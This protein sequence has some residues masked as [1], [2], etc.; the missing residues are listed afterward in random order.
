MSTVIN[1]RDTRSEMTL[2]FSFG[3][4]QNRVSICETLLCQ[5][6]LCVCHLPMPKCWTCGVAHR[7]CPF[8]RSFVTPSPAACA[9][10]L[11]CL[12]FPVQQCS[13]C[14]RETRWGENVWP[15]DPRS[16]VPRP[17]DSHT[18]HPEDR[19]HPDRQTWSLGKLFHK[20]KQTLSK[21]TKAVTKLCLFWRLV[22]Y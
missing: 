17:H 10:L 18:A 16:Q 13:V 2:C 1:Q 14:S 19:Q 22:H 12:L 15:L 20:V 3:S 7:F 8:M 21:K 9:M 5:T 11:F 6:C 4:T